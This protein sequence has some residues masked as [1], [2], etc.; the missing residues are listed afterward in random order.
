MN[1]GCWRPYWHCLCGLGCNAGSFSYNSCKE[2][3]NKEVKHPL[4]RICCMNADAQAT[5]ATVQ[6]VAVLLIIIAH[7]GLLI[8]GGYALA[9]QYYGLSLDA[10]HVAV[11]QALQVYGDPTSGNPFH[12][13][14]RCFNKMSFCNCIKCYVQKNAYAAPSLVHLLYVQMQYSTAHMY[15][16]H[17]TAIQY[18][19]HVPKDGCS[20]VCCFWQG[21]QDCQQ[22][23]VKT[24]FCH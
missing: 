12:S 19:S 22:G 23:P 21:N 2:V 6:A 14:Q 9:N 17:I 5:L 1:I 20:I 18:R 11:N 3:A 24:T 15:I 8:W 10:S 7:D 4:T 13:N 16:L